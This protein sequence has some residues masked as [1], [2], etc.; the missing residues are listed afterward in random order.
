[1]AGRKGIA[2]IVTTLQK[3]KDADACVPRYKHLREALG[4]SFGMDTELPLTRI[5]ETNGLDDVLWA[6]EH[7]IDVGDKILRLWA[8]DCAA[9]VQHIWLAKYPN[10][11][12][13]AE[14]IKASRQFARGE[15]T[16]AAYAARAAAA[17]AARD[18]AWAARDAAYA[19][20]DA[21]WVAWS[22]AAWVAWSAAAYAARDTARA[23]YTARDAA[24]RDAEEKWQ[25]ERLI[26]YLKDEVT[27]DYERK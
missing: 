25:T 9:H 18:A 14:A 22:D 20:R 19:A 8:A 11:R 5:L 24:A 13:P 27:E 16:A 6:M 21:A 12:R 10:D 3:L 26:A 2:M 17:R 23:A 4:K 15:I 1:M 7:V